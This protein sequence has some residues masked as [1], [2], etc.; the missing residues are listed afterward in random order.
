[1]EFHLVASNFNHN[2]FGKI[3][4]SADKIAWESCFPNFSS[5]AEGEACK[6]SHHTALQS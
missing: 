5:R 4:Y 1:M 6:I 2:F 3:T